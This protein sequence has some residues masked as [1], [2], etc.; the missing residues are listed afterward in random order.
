MIWLLG[1][2]IAHNHLQFLPDLT[3]HKLKFF[4]A[5]SNPLKYKTQ[6]LPNDSLTGSQI[7]FY[8]QVHEQI[9]GFPILSQ[10]QRMLSM[11]KIKYI[12]DIIAEIEHIMTQFE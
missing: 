5:Q 3:Q 9:Q 2:N 10:N 1:L 6:L 11:F 12:C 7:K 8:D 4:Q